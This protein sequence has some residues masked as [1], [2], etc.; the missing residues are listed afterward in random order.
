[1]FD[2]VALGECLIDFTPK[3]LSAQG[4]ALFERNPGGAPAN[5]AVAVARLGGSG[6]FIGKV[7]ND[8][9]GQFLADTMASNGV[10]ISGLSFSRE[11]PTTLAFVHLDGKG[12][13]SFSFYR[14][15]GADILLS[16]A[17]VRL[18]LI[19]S[20][21]VFHF[22]S[23]SMTDEPSRTATLE[24]A[25]YAREKGVIV[26][27]DPNLRPALWKSMDEAREWIIKGFDHAHIVKV[28]EEELTFLT[29]EPDLRK[30]AMALYQRFQPRILLVTL[31]ERGCIFT[32]DGCMDQLPASKVDAIDTTGAGDAFLGGFLY[33][34][35]RRD[36]LLADLPFAYLRDAVEFANFAG[37]L[38]TTKSGA[39]PA[40][41]TL[42]DVWQLMNFS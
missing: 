29:G 41:P 14:T 39:I 7:G 6:A 10:D 23:V 32:M 36:C 16:C 12:D 25:R 26:S 18:S 1:M 15:P 33:F 31:G 5:V 3:G 21:R 20:A 27:Y 35:T 13:R 34:L 17:D 42:H 24:A 38:A 2:I 30:G 9:F 37:A 8:A 28:S 22:G 4:N 40:L 11:A 19:D